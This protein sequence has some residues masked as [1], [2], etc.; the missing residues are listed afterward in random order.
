MENK[1]NIANEELEAHANELMEA[2]T[3]EGI[4]VFKRLDD[5]KRQVKIQTG[6]EA[7]FAL[8]A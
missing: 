5:E 7:Y 8:L 4:V 2:V 3:K 1:E 6:E